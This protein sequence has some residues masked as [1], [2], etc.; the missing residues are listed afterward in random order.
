LADFRGRRICVERPCARALRDQA[1]ITYQKTVLPAFRD[2]ENAL[3]AFAKEQQHRKALND[4]A[5]ANHA[6]YKALSGCWES[7]PFGK[8]DTTQG[9]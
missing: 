3:I 8:L 1:F 7:V 5:V 2:V 6:L 4:A 9:K